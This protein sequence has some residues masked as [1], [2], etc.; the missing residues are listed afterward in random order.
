[1]PVALIRP[2][3]VS[4]TGH[5]EAVNLTRLRTPVASRVFRVD[6]GFDRVTA[7]GWG[8]FGQVAAFGG[9]KLEFDEVEARW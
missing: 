8:L 2:N 5:F 3:S 7:C 6:P 1:M 9:E 4:D